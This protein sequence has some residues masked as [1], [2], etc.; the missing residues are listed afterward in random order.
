MSKYSRDRL[1][2]LRIDTGISYE[3]RR[4]GTTQLFRTQEQLG[5]AAKDKA[6]LKSSNVPFELPDREGIARIEPALAAVK[7]NFA[8]DWHL[9]NDQ[10]GD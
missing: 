3:G 8:A 6:V 7:H 9:P 1:D 10:T 5:A 4:L 2:E